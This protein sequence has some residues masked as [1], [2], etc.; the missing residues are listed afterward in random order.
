[1]SLYYIMYFSNKDN[2]YAKKIQ[3][4]SPLFFICFLLF[5]RVFL[6][7]LKQKKH[8]FL[9]K[10]FVLKQAHIT[11]WD[12]LI[13]GDQMKLLIHIGIRKNAVSGT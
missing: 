4:F 5:F 13:E 2:K 10:T 1:M 3:K 6:V 12:V 7:V 11:I 8:V 9:K